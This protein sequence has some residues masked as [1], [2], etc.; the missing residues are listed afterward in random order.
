MCELC[1]YIQLTEVGTRVHTIIT[2]D[3]DIGDAGSVEFTLVS[4]GDV[5]TVSKNKQSSLNIFTYVRILGSFIQRS[6]ILW[7]HHPGPKS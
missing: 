2:S 4:N 1:K 7:G 5:V 3:P 6:S